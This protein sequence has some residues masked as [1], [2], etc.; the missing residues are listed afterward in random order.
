[1][2]TALKRP[3][4]CSSCKFED[5]ACTPSFNCGQQGNT[6][7]RKKRQPRSILFQ[8]DAESH[9]HVCIFTGTK[10]C[11][12]LFVCSSDPVHSI[13]FK[14]SQ[15]PFK[16]MGG[17]GRGRYQASQPKGKGLGAGRTQRLS[18]ARGHFASISVRRRC[19][20]AAPAGGPKRLPIA[21]QAVL[22][23]T[24]DTGVT[25]AFEQARKRPIHAVWQHGT[26]PRS[27]AACGHH[28]VSK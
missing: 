22:T 14:N 9:C 7:S 5:N 26:W 4:P 1:M 10:C 27:L 28:I 13:A 11:N 12:I 8:T 21:R 6:G 2:P 23:S 24:P 15:L 17:R 20:P 19:N 18:G 25:R 16:T 3:A